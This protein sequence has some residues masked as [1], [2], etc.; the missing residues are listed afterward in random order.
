MEQAYFLTVDW[1]DKGRRGI[2][3]SAQGQA[4]RK[5]A[6]HTDDEMFDISARFI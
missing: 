2:F 1:C 5:D 6:L 3:C 4:Y